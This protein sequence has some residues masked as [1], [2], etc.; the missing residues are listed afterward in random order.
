LFCTTCGKDIKKHKDKLGM[1]AV[2]T[3]V[4]IFSGFE[5]F[6]ILGSWGGE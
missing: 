1:G 4:L 5:L 6:T 3:I 2:F